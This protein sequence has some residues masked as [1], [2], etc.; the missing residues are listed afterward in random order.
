MWKKVK[1]YSYRSIFREINGSL[2]ILRQK[3][4]LRLE[5]RAMCFSKFF[6]IVSHHSKAKGEKSLTSLKDNKNIYT[7][8]EMSNALVISKCT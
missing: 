3:F 1:T 5:L 6:F 8:D 4:E 7:F 2:I